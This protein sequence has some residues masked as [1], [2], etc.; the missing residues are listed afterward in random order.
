VKQPIVKGHPLHAMASD[1]PTAGFMISYLFDVVSRTASPAPEAPSIEAVG[2]GISHVFSKSTRQQTQFKAA[3]TYTLAAGVGGGALAGAFG[4]WDFL[5]IPADHPA[6]TPALLH[7]LLNTGLLTLGGINLLT[8]RGQ[9]RWG[10]TA[11]VPF[12]LSSVGIGALLVSAWIGGDL[13]YRPRLA[14]AAGRGVGDLG[15]GAKEGR[16][17]S[18]STVRQAAS[19]AVREGFGAHPLSM[20][21]PQDL[22]PSRLS[23]RSRRKP[24]YARHSAHQPLYHSSVTTAAKMARGEE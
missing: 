5:N 1:L 23:G 22:Q 7:G 14:C 20:G 4:W 17:R 10:S 16:Q 18:A 13:V 3:A 8:R 11:S 21:A 12:A 2:G 15:V 19:G 6:R 9:A 24:G